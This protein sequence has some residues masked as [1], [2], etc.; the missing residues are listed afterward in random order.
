MSSALITLTTD[1]GHNDYYV[2]VVKGVIAGIAPNARV[3]DVTHG[4]KQFSIISAAWVLAQTHQFFPPGTIHVV[5]IDPGV[6][7]A[8]R[9]IAV[10]YHDAIFVG[11]DNG[12]FSGLSLDSATV[13]ELTEPGFWRDT[14]SSTFHARDVYGPVAAHLANG[15]R[16]EKMGRKVETDTLKQCSLPA[17]RKTDGVTAGSVVYI[18]RYGNLITNI[19]SGDVPDGAHCIVGSVEAGFLSTTYSSVAPGNPVVIRGSHGYIEISVNQGEAS[20][21]FRADVGTGVFIT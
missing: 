16:L 18:D 7:G 15:E 1:F 17:S 21:F 9:P 20:E 11:P 2:G 8:Q 10:E 12:V 5:V 14:V 4:I 13:W 19:P 6:G 3:I